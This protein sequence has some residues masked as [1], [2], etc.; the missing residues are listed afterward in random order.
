[1]RGVNRVMLIGNLGQGGVEHHDVVDGGVAA[2]I[3][4]AELRGEELAGVVQECQ[5]G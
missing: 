4:R 2:R 1:M 3:S 5:H